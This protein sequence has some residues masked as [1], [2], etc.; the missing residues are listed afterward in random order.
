MVWGGDLSFRGRWVFVSGGEAVELLI[1]VG[2][3]GNFNWVGHV[4]RVGST[5]VGWGVAG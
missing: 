2:E 3:N 4:L 1:S 5:L